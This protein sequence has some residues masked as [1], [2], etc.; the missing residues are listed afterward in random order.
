[1]LK[2]AVSS[3][4]NFYDKTLPILL[5]SLINSGFSK[6]D[7]FIFISGSDIKETKILDGFTYIFTKQNSYEYTPLIE[8]VENFIESE[9]W[10]LIHDTCKVGPDF[11]KL[12]TN[13]PETKPYKIALKSKPSMSIGA[14][15]YDYLL[16]NKDKLLKIKNE[17]LSDKS[18]KEWKHWGVFNEDYILWMTPPKPM[19][20]GPD[21]WYVVDYNNW[22]V[23]ETIR[24]T[25]YYNSLDLYKNKSNWGQTG[26][27]M[28][29]T[30]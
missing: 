8:I 28:I 9:Y 5:P 26:N 16:M 29:I 25:E 24:R 15:R 3:N 12:V 30:L 4:I 22:Y 17:D 11:K 20:Y 18:L 21:N 27:N 6:N 1:M 23:N 2:I 10:F 13:I 14:Y 19:L 7:I